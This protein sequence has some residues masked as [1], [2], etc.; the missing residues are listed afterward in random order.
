MMLQREV[1]LLSKTVNTVYAFIQYKTIVLNQD[2][3]KN[4]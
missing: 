1:D 2:F 4:Y 3:L